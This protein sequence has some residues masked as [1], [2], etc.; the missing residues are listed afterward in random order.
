MTGHIYIKIHQQHG[1]H[2]MKQSNEKPGAKIFTLEKKRL[3]NEDIIQGIIAKSPHAASALY[4]SFGDSINRLVWR[5]LGADQDHD[6]VVQQVFVNVISSINKVDNAEA[7]GQWI[8]DVTVNTVRR[9]IRSRKYRRIL[10]LVDDYDE[11]ISESPEHGRNLVAGR[12]YQLLSSMK[13]DDRI[14]FI[15]RFVEKYTVSETALACGISNSTAK[16]RISRAKTA[17][18]M[19]AEKDTVLASYIEEMKNEQ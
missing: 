13:T 9:E 15:L 2:A 7:L 10:Y 14:V 18:L 16:R 6:D 3:N 17:F 8:T 4:D 11:S 1:F 12:T 5:L 19:R